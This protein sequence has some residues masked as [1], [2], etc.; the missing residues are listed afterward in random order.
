VLELRSPTGARLP[1]WQPG[2]HIDLLLPGGLIRQY[3]LCGDPAITAHTRSR[4]YVKT[5]AEG[6]PDSFMMS[7]FVAGCT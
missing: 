2:A 3:P 4:C 7:W 5:T 1:S 6:G